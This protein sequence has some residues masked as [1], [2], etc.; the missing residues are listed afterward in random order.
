MGEI[1]T[2]T[3][4]KHDVI[5]NGGCNENWSLLYILKK[6]YSENAQRQWKM[7]HDSKLLAL[8]NE[9]MIYRQKLAIIQKYK[10]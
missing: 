1:H 2:K 8:K 7:I 9:N 5:F 6:D 3:E 10:A 4:G